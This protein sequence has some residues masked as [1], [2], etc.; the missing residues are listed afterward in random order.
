MVNEKRLI[1]ANALKE[2]LWFL[3]KWFGQ[4]PCSE[5]DKHTQE[6]IKKCI[7]EV[8]KLPTVDAVEVVRCEACKQWFST[9]KRAGNREDGQ[10]IGHCAVA[11][12]GRKAND[13]CSYGERKEQ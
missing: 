4:L 10:L 13:F 2:K 3:F 5:E 7:A 9:G 6:T 8:D 1:D 12:Y 11:C